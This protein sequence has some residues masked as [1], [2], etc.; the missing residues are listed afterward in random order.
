MAKLAAAIVGPGWAAGEHIKGYVQDDRTEVRAIVGMI[1]ED[2]TRAETYMNDFGFHADYIEDL[3]TLCD[4]DDIDVVSICTRNYQHYEQALA[5][6][7]AGKHVLV[8]KPLCLTQRENNALKAAAES[9]G[10][11]THVG[12]IGRFYAALIGLKNFRDAAGI[13]EVFYAEADY[14]HEII[15]AWKCQPETGGSSLLMGGCHAVD[16]VRWMVGEEHNVVEVS[17]MSVPAAR[18]DEFGYD[19]T[20]ATIFRFDN[21]AVGRVSSSLECNMP[22]VFH[23]QVNGTKGAFRNNGISSEMFPGHEREFIK[24]K[25]QYP[26]DWNVTGHPFPEEISYVVDCVMNQTES[27]VSIPRA[28]KTYELIFAAERSAREG[29]RIKLPLT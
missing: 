20:I 26:D 19:P 14:W 7:E 1:P 24:L 21:G 4:R 11:T 6:I 22:Y 23:L 5:C 27:M 15:G 25:S 9:A 12:H 28:W 8:E 18:R 16:A 2:K 10:V 13:G 3:S 17:A 29:R